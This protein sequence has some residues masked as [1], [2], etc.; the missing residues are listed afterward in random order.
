MS[1]SVNSPVVINEAGLALA[2]WG[3]SDQSIPRIT[4]KMGFLQQRQHGKMV[5][6]QN[7]PQR[8]PG[9]DRDLDDQP[10]SDA[11]VGMT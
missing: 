4:L 2:G 3:N 10:G 7:G 9:L 1:T 11:P 5:K 6:W 8:L